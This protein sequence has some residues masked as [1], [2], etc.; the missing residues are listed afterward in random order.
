MTRKQFTILHSNDIHGDILPEA[1]LQKGL[2]IGG[3]SLLSGYLKKVREQEKN[4]IFTI[5]GDMLQGSLIDSEYKGVSTIE[6]LNYLG[7]DV[8]TLG[9][10]E[11]DYGLSHLLFLE[12]M[13]N[14]PIVTANLYI[15][16]YHRRL[17]RPYVVLSI[18]G[19]K[20]LFIGIITEMVLQFLQSDPIIGTL[21]SL[22][23][24][25]Q[26]ITQICDAF[27]MDDIDLT[28]LLTHIGFEN[29]KK[30][31]AMLDPALG[32]DFILGGHSHTRLEKP[33]LVKDILIAQ[34]GYGTNQIGRFD[35]EVDNDT[36]RI[37][38]W[39][40]QLIPI[41]SYLCE[42]DEGLDKFINGY[43]EKV[44]GKYNALIG[45]L[46][47]VVTHIRREGETS[48]GNLVAD[49]LNIMA[50]NDITL[51]NSGFIRGDSL[52]PVVTLGDLIRLFPYNEALYRVQ[53]RGI[54]LKQIINH[55]LFTGL[56]PF[57]KKDRVT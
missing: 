55:I 34:S 22:E 5:S 46:A 37:V 2:D 49:I 32:V 33:E 25:V 9:N 17:M 35:I 12:K 40:W 30:L 1:D 56:W 7:P 53:V 54:W 8:A 16:K 21:I 3:L 27:K 52:G 36:N 28:V 41:D 57:L 13:A 26:E 24:P 51:I 10:H 38:D 18:E 11:M 44:N 4:V 19:Y 45:R 50:E 23:D 39:K 42:S 6:I 47:R 29:D 48:L 20:I 43:S 14:F 31:A 15:N